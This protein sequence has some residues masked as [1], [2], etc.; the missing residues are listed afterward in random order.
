MSVNSLQYAGSS[1]DL[2]QLDAVD[3]SA[4]IEAREV[5]CVEVMSATLDRIE[6]L[7]PRFNAIVALRERETLI[8]EARNQDAALAHGAKPG[9]LQGFPIA[10]KDLEPVKGLP[11]T[12]GAP[13]F[14]DRVA[15]ADSP[16]V[17]RLRAAGAIIIG[18]TNVPEFGLG[19]QTTNPVYGATRNAYDDRLTSGGSSGGAAVALALRMAPVADGSDF[20]GSLRNPAGW[21]NVYGFRPSFGRIPKERSDAWTPSMTVLGPM[22]R[23][24]ADLALLFS[25]QAGYDARDP[26]SLEGDGSR[27][28]DALEADIRGKRIAWVG[29]FGGAL[30][31]EPGVLELG[32]AAMQTFVDLGC[33]VEEAKPDFPVED[34]WRAFVTLRHWQSSGDLLDA[35]RDPQKRALLKPAAIYE[36]ENGLA[37]SAFDISAASAART[38]WS[39]AIRRFFERYDFWALPTA[40]VFPF[41]VHQMWP[42][43][44]AGREMATYHE[45]M[46]CSV[47][48]TLSGCPTLA[49]PAGFNAAGLPMGVQIVA[50]N[51]AEMDLLR[52][53]RAYDLATRWPDRRPPPALRERSA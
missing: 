28:R 47:P 32:R 4:L 21:N 41:D 23:N 36:V 25:V 51:H 20:G 43:Q 52:L 44:I 38:R 37:L 19:S 29:D 45:W 14:R 24:V 48:A 26:L 42:R 46:K 2:L 30:P 6:A 53:G 3:L 16:M 35:Y 5:S 11:F 10:V 12:K 50:P 8:A 49:A 40:Q 27:F 9:P 33:I 17:E 31:F 22:A 1:S 18:K 7:N 15:E 13:I 39:Q 34:A